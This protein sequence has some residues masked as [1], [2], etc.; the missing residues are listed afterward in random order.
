VQ[1]T[2]SINVL[3]RA[4]Y[5]FTGLSNKMVAVNAKLTIDPTSSFRDDDGHSLT[6]K[7]AQ[8]TFNSVPYPIPGS[9]FTKDS[10]KI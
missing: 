10:S 9:F 4:P 2:L 8:Y 6:I 3:N 7:D 5:Q 1:E